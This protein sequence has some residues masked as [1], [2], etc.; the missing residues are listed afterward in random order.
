MEALG[1][2]GSIAPTLDGKSSQIHARPRFTPGKRTL[3]THCAGGWVGPR[4]GMDTQLDEKSA[5]SAGDRTPLVR[6]SSPWLDTTLPELAR[7]IVNTQS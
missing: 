1:G 4:A 3:G 7:L 2:R 5:A 6:L